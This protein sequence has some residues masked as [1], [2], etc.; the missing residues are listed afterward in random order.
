[1]KSKVSLENGN[2]FNKFACFTSLFLGAQSIFSHWL[3]SIKKS[4]QAKL[5]NF[6]LTI[7]SVAQEL[8][9][10]FKVKIF[11]YDLFEE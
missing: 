3:D 4:P 10:R 5:R 6:L 2:L 9:Q 7:F 1:M 8:I 11:I